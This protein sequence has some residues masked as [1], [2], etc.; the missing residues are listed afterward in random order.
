[1]CGHFPGVLERPALGK[2]AAMAV[3]QFRLHPDGEELLR[4]IPK[5]PTSPPW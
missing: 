1:M 3:A 5:T 2:A 4:P